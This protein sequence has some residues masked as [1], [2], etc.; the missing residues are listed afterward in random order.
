MGLVTYFILPSLL[1]FVIFY[2]YVSYLT[3][4]QQVILEENG[5][6]GAGVPR[7]DNPSIIPFKVEVPETILMD[8]KNRLSNSRITHTFLEDSNDFWYGFNSKTLAEFKDYWLHEYNWRKQEAII[9]EFKHF[10]T[11]IEGLKVHFIRTIP[12]AKYEKS[13][14]LLIVHGWPGNVFE[15]Y[16]LIPILTDPIAFGFKSNIAFEV[17]APSIP[18]Y[19][20]SEQPK[21]TGF[22]QV[23]CA[24]IFRKLMDRLGYEKF[25]LQGGD[26]GSLVSTNIARLF[27]DRVLGIHLNMISV[28]L[29]DTI[30]S[31]VLQVLGSVFP[32]LLFSSKAHENF[33]VMD[34]ALILIKEGGYLH[35]QATKPDTVGTALNDSPLGLAA[36]ILEKFSTWTNLNNRDLPDGGLTRKFTKEELLTIVMIYWINGNI[37][38]SQRFYKEAFLDNK[39]KELGKS[40]LNMSSPIRV[41][42]T[43]AAGQIGYSLVLQIAKGDVFGK[44]PIVLV[45][46]DIPPMAKV[47]EGVQFELQD[48][49]LPNLFGKVIVVGNPANTNSFICAKYAA[50]KIPAKNFSAM[51]R[52][53][54]NRAT[55]QLAMKAGVTIKDVKNVIIWGNHSGTQFPD[56][57]HAQIIKGSSSIDAYSAINDT[58]FLQ[59]PF[60][61]IVQKRGA[62]II[63]KRKLSSAMS[64]AKAACD[65]IHD[66][67]F[68]T[69]PVNSITGYSLASN[70]SSLIDLTRYFQLQGEWVSMAVPSDG[71]YGVPQG[72]IFSFPVTIDGSTKEWKIVQGLELDEFAKEKMAITTKELEE[73]R[74][75]AL[76][77]CDDANM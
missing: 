37:V 26:W 20:W 30:K 56:V 53:D 70:S 38:A 76:K 17:I 42:V 67:H 14:P 60:I 12:D 61:S 64:A 6:F 11:E 55:A 58:A 10:K 25:Y 49:A 71:S 7:N 22:S 36:Y 35:L 19:G 13:L 15:F 66:W 18:G 63:E 75:E 23:A 62:V 21:K 41:L 24:R 65:H 45:L 74:E 40:K 50:G 5:W 28:M 44:T 51:T 27:P 54:H 32:K 2:A 52:L 48:C 9:N 69:K 4:N 31:S 72:L 33:S 8:L 16:K 43:G 77:A 39:N 59:G 73:E 1:A 46:L 47:L 57:K 3:S 68:G 29:G 34:K